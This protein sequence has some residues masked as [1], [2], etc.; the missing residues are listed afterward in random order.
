MLGAPVI[1]SCHDQEHRAKPVIALV[2]RHSA[3]A[4]RKVFEVIVRHRAPTH[5]G[6][7]DIAG[8]PK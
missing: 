6:A 8:Q 7:P 1:I 3:A 4:I 5:A 2:A